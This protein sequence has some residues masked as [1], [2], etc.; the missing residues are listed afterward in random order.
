MGRILKVVILPLFFLSMSKGGMNSAF[1]A[2]GQDIKK[3]RAPYK[4]AYLM[5]VGKITQ[6]SKAALDD[7]LATELY[8]TTKEVLS[9]M[10]L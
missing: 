8:D 3:D 6:P 9:E 5:P 7:R 1:A 2:A 10:G 4:G